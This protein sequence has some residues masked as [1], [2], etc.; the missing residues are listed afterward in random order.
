VYRIEDEYETRFSKQPLSIRELVGLIDGA[1]GHLDGARGLTS[2]YRNYSAAWC[3]PENLVEFVT[4]TSI[5]YPE[6]RAYYAEEAGEWLAGARVAPC[7][8]CGRPPPPDMIRANLAIRAPVSAL[9]QPESSGWRDGAGGA[10]FRRLGGG[11]V[12]PTPVIVGE[13]GARAGGR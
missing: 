7:P 11:P 1:T 3:D 9:P 13:R 8:P 6:L 10:T 12:M 4:V 2:A 5:F